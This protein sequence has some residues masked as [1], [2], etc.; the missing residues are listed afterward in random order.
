MVMKWHWTVYTRHRRQSCRVMDSCEQIFPI[1]ITSTQTN[2]WSWYP[3]G[4]AFVAPWWLVMTNG[5]VQAGPLVSAP[6]GTPQ[7]HQGPLRD[8]RTELHCSKPPDLHLAWSRLRTP[9]DREGAEEFLQFNHCVQ[10]DCLQDGWLLPCVFV[11]IRLDE[12]LWCAL[13]EFRRHS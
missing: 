9:S 4:S 11:F 8:R 12:V 13:I 2:Q 3:G 6:A 10:M 1:I 7:W 5:C